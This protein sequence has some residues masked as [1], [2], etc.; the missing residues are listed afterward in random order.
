MNKEVP[1]IVF[2]RSQQN[3]QD[4][5]TNE[6]RDEEEALLRQRQIC[7]MNLYLYRKL[8]DDARFL[9]DEDIGLSFL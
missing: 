4:Y 8:G 6:I 2:M 9:L 1:Y 3:I 5:V 7:E